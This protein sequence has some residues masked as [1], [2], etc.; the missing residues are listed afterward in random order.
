MWGNILARVRRLARRDPTVVKEIRYDEHAN[1]E[2]AVIVLV[3]SLIGALTEAIY[4]G[5]FLSTLFLRLITGVA[6]NWLLWSYVTTFILRHYYGVDAE[7]WQM[8]RLM[9][10]ANIPMILSLA[11]IFGCVGVLFPLI[12]GILALIMAFVMIREAFDLSTERTVIS[13][14]IGWVVVLLLSILVNSLVNTK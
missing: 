5:S 13:I 6:L 12:G 1:R 2:A 10:Y 9:G 4:S 8:A 3:V 14:A 7:F 11:R